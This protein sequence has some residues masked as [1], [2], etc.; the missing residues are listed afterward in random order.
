MAASL[1]EL[2]KKSNVYQWSESQAK[3]FQALKV[4]LCAAPILSYPATR[5]KFILYSDSNGYGI[6]GVAGS[7]NRTLL[8][9]ER[10]YCV[11]RRELF[12]GYLL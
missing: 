3:V 10:N 4:L 11:N 2:T 7:N 5:E 6:G 8:K 9:P 1:H 12:A